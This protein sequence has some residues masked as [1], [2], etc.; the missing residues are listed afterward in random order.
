M[1]LLL[2]LLAAAAAAAEPADWSSAQK[3]YKGV[4]EAYARSAQQYNAHVLESGSPLD[5]EA[6]RLK[7]DMD[8]LRERS[9]QMRREL[10]QLGLP[11]PSAPEARHPAEGGPWG[12]ASEPPAGRGSWRATARALLFLI[13]G[14]VAL[15]AFWL[16]SA[17]YRARRKI[18]IRC[19]GCARLLRVPS[20]RKRLRVRCPG[21]GRESAY[22][23][24]KKA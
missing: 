13:A 21:C 22:N 14:A 23:P 7:A 1:S 4:R 19:P 16:W 18:T 17:P 8:A 3:E 10:S 5:E 12:T 9:V 2:L 24:R 6:K 20:A 11:E 15:E